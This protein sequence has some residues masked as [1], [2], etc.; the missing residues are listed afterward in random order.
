MSKLESF[1]KQF[2]EAVQ[3]FDEVLKEKKT[4]I[5]RDA[6]IKRFEFTFD[7]AW[8]LIR[9]YLREKKGI[10]CPSPKDCIQAAYRHGLIEY[11]EIWVQIT[12]WRNEAVHIY[13]E[14]YEEKLYQDLPR[15]LPLFQ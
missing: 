10:E 9:A 5:V 14:K 15:V 3:R 2:S 12:D 8:K 1:K 4:I 7:L 11:D 6:A 13:S